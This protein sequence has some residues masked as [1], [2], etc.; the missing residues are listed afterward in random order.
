MSIPLAA[1]MSTPASGTAS[2]TKLTK[3]GSL[4]QDNGPHYLQRCEDV[5]IVGISCRTAGGN[6]TPEKLWQFLLEQRNASGELPQWRWETWRRRDARN[7]KELEKTL[8]K[9]YF[10]KNI[11]DFDA[12]FFGIS[13]R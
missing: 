6:D 11:E 3:L 13:P 9:A 10:I 8:C 5:A 7:A 4:T 2:S 1:N 12:S